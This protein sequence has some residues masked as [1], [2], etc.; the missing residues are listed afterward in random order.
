MI[1]TGRAESGRQG[2]GKLLSLQFNR[3]KLKRVTAGWAAFALK[4]L[5]IIM[6]VLVVLAGLAIAL[7]ISN[8]R[9]ASARV[10]ENNLR[11]I[12]AATAAY[13]KQSNAKLPY[14]FISKADSEQT[15]WDSLIKPFMQAALRTDPNVPPPSGNMIAK[16]FLCPDDKLPGPFWGGREQPRRTYAMP[17]HTMEDPNWPPGPN[18]DTGLGLVWSFRKKGY[19]SVKSIPTNGLP[20]FTLDALLDPKGTLYLTE[21]AKTNNVIFNSSGAIVYYTG[22]QLDARIQP[23][24]YHHGKLSYL[25]ADGHVKTLYPEQTVGPGGDVGTDGRKHH[26]MWTVRPGD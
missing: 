10:C 4:E 25:M 8:K 19:A 17:P 14:A 5:L 3:M 22:N 7:L 20:A 12:F 13:S 24:E 16:I 21:E 6:A 26:G 23:G 18:N 9:N 1:A 2:V 11:Q 15:S